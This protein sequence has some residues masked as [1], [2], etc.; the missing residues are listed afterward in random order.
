MDE[1][2]GYITKLILCM[3]ICNRED[4]VI[5]VAQIINK[6]DG[7]DEFTAKDEELFR[8]YLTFCGIGIQNAQLFEMSVLEYRRNQVRRES[9]LLQPCFFLEYVCLFV[10]IFHRFNLQVSNRR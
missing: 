3:P 5:G 4:E 9:N 1:R 6:T 8:R 2:T 7:S 10:N